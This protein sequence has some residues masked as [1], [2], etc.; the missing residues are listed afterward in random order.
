[1]GGKILLN[2]VTLPTGN[3]VPAPRFDL[4]PTVCCL[5]AGHLCGLS[6]YLPGNANLPVFLIARAALLGFLFF[7]LTTL[8]K[9]CEREPEEAGARYDGA[10]HAAISGYRSVFLP[11]RT[12]ETVIFSIGF[13][14]SNEISSRA[15]LSL[16]QLEALTCWLSRFN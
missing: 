16:S 10:N 4:P 15:S 2:N 3:Y 13:T 5:V 14:E 12:A 7:A 6:F 8:C 11:Y 9:R 1:M